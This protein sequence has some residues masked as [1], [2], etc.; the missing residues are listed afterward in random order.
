MKAGQK[1]SIL[2][3]YHRWCLHCKADAEMMQSLES[4]EEMP[5]ERL[6]CFYQQLS[7]GTGGLRGVMGVGTAR[8]NVYTVA[9]ATQGLAEYLQEEGAGAQGVAIAYDSRHLGAQFAQTAADVLAGNGIPVYLFPRLAPTPLLSFSVRDFHC[10]AGICVTASHNPAQYNGY[11]VYG[12]DGCQITVDAA[13]AIQK[14]IDG[15]DVLEGAKPAS[16]GQKQALIHTVTEE[17]FVRYIEA[18]KKQ[19]MWEGDAVA[20]LHVVYTPLYGAGRECILR[21][22]NE[23]GVEKI[24]LVDCQKEPNGDFPTCPYPNPEEKAALEEGLKLCLRVHSDLLL[25]TDPDSD[26]VGIAVEHEGT[27]QLLTGNEVGI[28][29]F[30]Y[31]CKSR[32]A[33]QT[34]PRNP[35]AVTTIVSTAMADAVA[36]RYG[37]ELRR[38]LTG[39]KFIGE[40]I[41][42]LEQAN[43]VER[44]IFGFEESYGYLS[45]SHVRDKDAVNASMLICQM[46]RF[47]KTQGKDLC[48]AMQMLYE[49]YGYY[50]NRLLSVTL[51]GASGLESM[52]KLMKSLRAT[53]PRVLAGLRVTGIVDYQAGVGALPPS[54]VLELQLEQACTV[55]IRPSGTE[56]KI[57]AYVSTKGSSAEEAAARKNKLTCAVENI[58]QGH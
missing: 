23:I 56:P 5:E 33:T 54:D 37:V 35:V 58:L 15:V 16:A 32:L 4:M 31:I 28:L 19:A 13:N 27:Y 18:V 29:L 9:K 21:I 47:Y 1:D 7:F 22:L 26:R 20:P 52:N 40:Q 30:D 51:S 25:A 53:P 49:T 2:E 11:K 41:G 42:F 34:M 43:E 24:T 12:S 36:N 3:E 10:A 6:D 14:K 50:Q 44:Y 55:I 48:Q 39:F 8:M 17:T 45:G 46:A 38:T 57:K